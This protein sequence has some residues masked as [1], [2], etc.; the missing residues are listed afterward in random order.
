M[1]MRRILFAAFYICLSLYARADHVAGGEISYQF[2]QKDGSRYQYR[3][4]LRLYR[5]CSSLEP[6]EESALL[7]V[8]NLSFYSKTPVPLQQTIRLPYTTLPSCAVNSPSGCFEVSIYETTLILPSS[9]EGYYLFYAGCCRNKTPV[10]ILTDGANAGSEDHNG[11]IVPGQGFT[12]RAFIPPHNLTEINSSPTLLQDSIISIC[13]GKPTRYRFPYED[14]DGDSLA[15]SFCGSLGLMKNTLPFF[16]DANYAPGFSG[17]A[18]MG[19]SPLVVLDPR[20]GTITGTPTRPG[21][22]TITLC[23]EEFRQGRHINTHRREQQ[24]HVYQ[25]DLQPPKDILNCE[26]NLALFTNT[27]NTENHYSWDFGVPGIG[28]DTSSRLFPLYHYPQ[29]GVFTVTLRATNPALG[30]S[31]STH[32]SVKIARGLAADFTWNDPICHGEELVLQDK[33]ST[34]FGQIKSYHW[35]NI[36]EQKTIGNTPSLTYNYSVPDNVVFP[37]SIQ[38]TVTNDSGCKKSILKVVEIQPRP[39]VHAGPDTVLARNQPYQMQGS[40][41]GSLLWSPV[42]GLN[43]PLLP[44]PT[45]TGNRDE[46]YVLKA[47]IDECAAYDTVVIRYFDSPDIFIPT[48][49]SPNGD[50]LN[51]ILHFLPVSMQV[52]R[53]YIYNRWGEALHTSTD[54]RKGWD[55]THKG[56][57]QPP[58]TYLWLVE[59]TD[60][61]G[62]KIT[63]KGTLQLIR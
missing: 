11:V 56:R 13:A 44:N 53:F 39:S 55:G 47:G 42:T 40:G 18:P 33:S 54:Y 59:A 45:L 6:L 41:T 30:C 50:G 52:R 17:T 26:S 3:V 63:K 14:A 29:D 23:I 27:N 35:E 24:V 2:M 19:G 51:D 20:S 16:T 43:N 22:Y 46:V 62:L 4:T 28:S 58:G 60:S 8:S 38:L 48:A 7:Q 37:L 12:F 34:P 61:N 57:P 31:D 25:C 9:T 49:F 21:F 10:N 15:Y 1:H 32:A 5:D 36:N